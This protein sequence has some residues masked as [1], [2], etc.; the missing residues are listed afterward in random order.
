MIAMYYFR[1]AKFRFISGNQIYYDPNGMTL[2]RAD[3]L[4]IALKRAYNMVSVGKAESIV[5]STRKDCEVPLRFVTKRFRYIVSV[6]SS[7]SLRTCK[8]LSDGR[9]GEILNYLLR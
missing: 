9:E 5:I 2:F 1:S 7:T 6:K 3:T 4:Q 8:L